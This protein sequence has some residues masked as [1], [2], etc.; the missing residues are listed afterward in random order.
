MLFSATD[1]QLPVGLG[2][3]G[4]CSELAH[5]LSQALA[6][7]GRCGTAFDLVAGQSDLLEKAALSGTLA[8][9]IELG[10]E[11]YICEVVSGRANNSNRLTGAIQAHL[12]QVWVIAP[13]LEV[14]PTVLPDQV[15]A[16]G[17]RLAWL[18][19]A[20]EPH[21]AVIVIAGDSLSNIFAESFRL[22]A[23][24]SVPVIRTTAMSNP[25]MAAYIL[26]CL[27]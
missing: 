10:L 14:L 16:A 4:A 3:S 23:L 5:H 21:P 18:A 17:K 1:R 11:D 24:S 15:D 25:E 9:V 26:K 19:S 13:F 22:W 20:A 27:G 7:I 2:V 8:A 6:G 12:P